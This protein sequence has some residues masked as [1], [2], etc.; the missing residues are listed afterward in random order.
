M[1]IPNRFIEKS[2]CKYSSLADAGVASLQNTY[3][4]QPSAQ[5]GTAGCIKLLMTARHQEEQ[6][7]LK[8]IGVMFGTYARQ[9]FGEAKIRLGG[10]DGN[11]FIKRF[12]LSD[13]ADNMYRYFELDSKRYT[14][15]EIVSITDSGVSTW[16]S[17][18][19]NG[20]IHTCIIYEYTN[21]KRRFTPG[22][23]YVP[24]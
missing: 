4:M 24:S 22:C 1:T 10:P 17:L 20:R 11:A 9:N 15:G 5:L 23:P 6:I 18:D 8:R 16:E 12:S 14:A 2:N 21:G 3:K 13:L 19:Q 7:G